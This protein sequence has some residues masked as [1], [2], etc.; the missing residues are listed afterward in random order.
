[1]YWCL[2]KHII[3]S[4]YDHATTSIAPVLDETSVLDNHLRIVEIVER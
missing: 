3:A 4:S 1:M 2:I